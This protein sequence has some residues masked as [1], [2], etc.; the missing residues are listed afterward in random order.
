VQG[1][2]L[3]CRQRR[4]DYRRLRTAIPGKFP[5]QGPGLSGV[6][7]RTKVP[8]VI[9][10]CQNAIC[11]ITDKSTGSALASSHGRQ[12][13]DGDPHPVKPLDFNGSSQLVTT[14]KS[15]Q[16]V[17]SAVVDDGQLPK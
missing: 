6:A 7:V 10:P 2:R 9:T 8:S 15:S 4:L 3:R 12:Q 5:W 17:P 1:R 11:H 13:N 14:P 16:Y